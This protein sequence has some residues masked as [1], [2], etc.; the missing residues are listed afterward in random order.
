M[1][2]DVL[3]LASPSDIDA[4]LACWR[5]RVANP[6]AVWVWCSGEPVT[7]PPDSFVWAPES[8]RDDTPKRQV[9]LDQLVATLV[10]LNANADA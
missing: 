8:P 2:N 3:T 7:T 9:L 1:P 4:A 6:D 10:S 5:D